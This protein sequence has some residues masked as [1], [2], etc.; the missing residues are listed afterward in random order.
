MLSNVVLSCEVLTHLNSLVQALNQLNIT[1]PAVVAATTPSD[2][3]ATTVAPAVPVV[4]AQV[5]PATPGLNTAPTVAAVPAV[6]NVPASQGEP[7]EGDA[8]CA[9]ACLLCVCSCHQSSAAPNVKR[10][11]TVTKGTAVGVFS[12]WATVSPLVTGVSRAVYFRLASHGEAS[13]TFNSALAHGDVE[14]L[15]A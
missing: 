11:Y 3:A 8:G 12:S 15:A 2:V 5:A 13:A 6:V 14:V 7:D 4:V 9:C 1:D 10:W